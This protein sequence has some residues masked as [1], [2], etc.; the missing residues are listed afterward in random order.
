MH[1]DLLEKVNTIAA[2]I[3]MPALTG[4]DVTAIHHRPSKADMTPG[5]I[6]RFSRQ[7]V[8][9]SCLH[10]SKK[11]RDAKSEMMIQENLTKQT[12][13]LLWEA[14]QWVREND[15]CVV[16]CANAKVL[17]RRKDGFPAVLA[18]RREDFSKFA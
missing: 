15:V 14:K 17:M 10:S 6:V 3:A 16:W 11:L 7:S 1:E 9:D 13:T 2:S 12:R 18:K 4:N 5:I 8:R